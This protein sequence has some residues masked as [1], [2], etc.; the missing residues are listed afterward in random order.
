MVVKD[1]EINSIAG[2]TLKFS[3]TKKN[4]QERAM[5]GLR[6]LSRKS[7]PK[8]SKKQCQNAAWEQ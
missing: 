7:H 4:D 6:K 2:H 3:L 5:I 1:D 8:N